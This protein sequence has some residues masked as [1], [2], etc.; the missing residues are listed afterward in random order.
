MEKRPSTVKNTLKQSKIKQGGMWKRG[1]VMVTGSERGW[2]E[3]ESES[4]TRR[5]EIRLESGDSVREG[6]ASS[7]AWASASSTTTRQQRIKSG[8]K[9]RPDKQRGWRTSRRCRRKEEQ[10]DRRRRKRQARQ[11]VTGCDWS[12]IRG[13]VGD[14]PFSIGNSGRLGSDA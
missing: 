8:A 10:E 13:W 11:Q 12:R 14:A 5:Q 9:E 2:K 7:C 4:T 6:Q 3:D 1:V